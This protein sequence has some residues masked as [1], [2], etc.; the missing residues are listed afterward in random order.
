VKPLTVRRG[1]KRRRREDEFPDRGN[2]QKKGMRGAHQ[3]SIEERSGEAIKGIIRLASLTSKNK[4]FPKKEGSRR[5]EPKRS[6]KSSNG[7]PT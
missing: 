1:R 3:I 6:K 5:G 4:N 7:S 2:A